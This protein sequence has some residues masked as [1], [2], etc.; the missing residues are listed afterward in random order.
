MKVLRESHQD[1]WYKSISKYIT[2]VKT[3]TCSAEP[4]KDFLQFLICKQGLSAELFH[5]AFGSF[6]E[7]N[8]PP[9]RMK[10]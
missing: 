10:L 8:L 5:T 3:V 4:G 1:R 9:Y 7:F 2:V 6:K